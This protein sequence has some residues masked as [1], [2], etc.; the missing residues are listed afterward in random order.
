MSKPKQKPEPWAVGPNGVYVI[1]GKD[2]IAI[3]SDE[4][5]AAR[6]VDCVN[7]CAGQNLEDVKLAKSY[8]N[9]CMLWESEMMRTIGEDGVGSVIAAIQKL[10]SE[11][12]ELLHELNKLKNQTLNYGEK[13]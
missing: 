10:K 5:H 6:I 3:C 7:A 8:K 9:A 2:V 4:V 11:R 13:L 12:D 1:T